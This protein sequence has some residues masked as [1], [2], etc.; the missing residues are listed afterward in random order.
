[1]DQENAVFTLGSF[2][3]FTESVTQLEKPGVGQ[4]SDLLVLRKALQP[5]LLA[6]LHPQGQAL[7]TLRF[8]PSPVAFASSFR[9]LHI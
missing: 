6:L 1:M 8:V 3:V 7:L 4:T 2:Q 9:L 5:H